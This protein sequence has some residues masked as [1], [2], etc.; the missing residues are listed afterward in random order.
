MG[1]RGTK[2]VFKLKA[3]KAQRVNGNLCNHYKWLHIRYT[4]MGFEKNYQLKNPS[5][6]LNFR[7]FSNLNSQFKMTP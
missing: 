3:V 1:D 5:K 7:Y 4:L 2:S 6:Q